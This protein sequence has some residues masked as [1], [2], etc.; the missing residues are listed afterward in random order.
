MRQ[1]RRLTTT[2]RPWH[3]RQF[4]LSYTLNLPIKKL[5]GLKLHPLKLLFIRNPIPNLLL[6]PLKRNNILIRQIPR[7]PNKLP[8]HLRPLHQKI[9]RILKF[10]IPIHDNMCPTNPQL[11]WKFL[12]IHF[13]RL[14]IIHP[15]DYLLELIEVGQDWVGKGVGALGKGEGWEAGL[16]VDGHAVELALGYYDGFVAC[17]YCV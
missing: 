10:L 16:L 4:S 8:N 1:K 11:L 6:D 17:G 12:D 15:E 13:A 14:V 3:N 9:I 5:K 7:L 2:R